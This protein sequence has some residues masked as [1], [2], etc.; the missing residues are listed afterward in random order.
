MK[1][2]T[3]QILSGFIKSME[4]DPV[5]WF[6]EVIGNTAYEVFRLIENSDEIPED[7]EAKKENKK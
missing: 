7:I 6:G 2:S 1:H 4:E 5:G 3:A